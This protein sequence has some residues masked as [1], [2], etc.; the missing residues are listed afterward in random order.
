MRLML[1]GF[2]PRKTLRETTSDSLI[3]SFAVAKRTE[4]VKIGIDG[5]NKAADKTFF[6]GGTRALQRE[7]EAHRSRRCHQSL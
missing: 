1:P 5:L 7:A 3:C 6:W 4:M 2:S